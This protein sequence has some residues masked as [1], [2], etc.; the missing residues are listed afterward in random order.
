MVLLTGGIFYNRRHDIPIKSALWNASERL[1]ST[2]WD[3]NLFE[4]DL[5]ERIT[6]IIKSSLKFRDKKWGLA[7]DAKYSN[8]VSSSV[9]GSSSSVK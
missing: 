7:S 8:E 5:L 1:K 4:F 3:A 9:P 6:S 2:N